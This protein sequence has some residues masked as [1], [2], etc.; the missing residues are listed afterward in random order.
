MPSFDLSFAGAEDSL[1]VRHFS[2]SEQLSSLFE[3]SVIAVSPVDDLDFEPI[4]GQTASF[5][6]RSDAAGRSRAPLAG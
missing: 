2:V 6:I 5:V 1:S 4:V 3:V